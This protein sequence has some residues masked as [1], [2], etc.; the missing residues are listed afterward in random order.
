M[1]KLNAVCDIDFIFGFPYILPLLEIMN[2]LIKIAQGTNVFVYDFVNVVKLV[3][4]ELYKLYYDP[5]V[6]FEDLAFDDF[7]YIDF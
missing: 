3:Q 6:K 7:N 5:Y 4:Q 1:K 2:T